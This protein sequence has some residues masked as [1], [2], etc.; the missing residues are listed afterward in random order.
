MLAQAAIPFSPGADHMKRKHTLWGTGG[1]HQ[2]V[3]RLAVA[4]SLAASS[5]E[6]VLPEVFRK[7]PLDGDAEVDILLELWS[8]GLLT[9]VLL[10]K[11]ALA[12][13]TVAPRAPMTALADIGT[14]GAFQGNAHRDLQRML[15]QG[16]LDLYIPPPW[17]VKLPLLDVRKRPPAKIQQDCVPHHDASRT[18]GCYV[19]EETLRV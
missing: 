12:A 3:A 13:C 14:H 1:K 5:H 19:V 4:A 2:R 16:P 7:G 9:A 10:Q 17:H 8:L 18:P 6:P 15:N 11:I